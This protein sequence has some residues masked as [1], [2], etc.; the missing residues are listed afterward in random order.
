V[1]KPPLPEAI[2]M[3]RD[4][5]DHVAPRQGGISAS[6]PGEEISEGATQVGASFE[7]E[8]R[9]GRAH[10]AGVERCRGR[11]GE[12]RRRPETAAARPPLPGPARAQWNP[13]A[14]TG[15]GRNRGTLCAAG[16][17]KQL[18]AGRAAEA[19]AGRKE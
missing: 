4:G 11:G 6:M 8:S 14:D 5:H 7:F 12:G 3:Q 15:G 10:P 16:R 2:L 17:A 13:A 9:D 1:V 19:T 18:A